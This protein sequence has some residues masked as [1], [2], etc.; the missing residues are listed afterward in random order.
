MYRPRVSRFR[1]PE[2]K[3]LQAEYYAKLRAEGF[4][5]IENVHGQLIDHQS[6]ADFSQ[7]A[8]FKAGYMEITRDYYTWAS[9]MVSL[10]QFVTRLDHHIWEL[11]AEG[12]TSREIQKVTQIEQSWVCRKI[13]KIR[14]YLKLQAEFDEPKASE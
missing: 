11:H 9:S 14:A 3:R 10:G 7:R 5:D 2:F 13:K 1:G 4:K 8:N 6:V 12:K